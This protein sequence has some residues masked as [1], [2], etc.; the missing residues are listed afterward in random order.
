VRA[1]DEHHELDLTPVFREEFA[2]T[3]PMHPLCRPDCPGLCV[4]CGGR[5]EEGDHAEHLGAE[6][7][8]RLAALADW[9]PPR[10]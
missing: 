10:D 6:V 4:V 9:K 1:I 5:L 8:P 2:L 3:E 7:D